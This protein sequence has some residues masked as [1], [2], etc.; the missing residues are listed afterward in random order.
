V[1][2]DAGLLRLVRTQRKRGTVEKYYTAVSAQIVV[3]PRMFG[4]GLVRSVYRGVLEATLAEVLKAERGGGELVHRLKIRTTKAK[5]E[6]L[7][8]QLQRWIRACR[9]TSRGKG[10]R[11]YGITV[12][13][14]PG[15]VPKRRGGRP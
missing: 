15:G 1:L 3:D 11:E 12:A 7:Q 8:R 5:A 14:Y 6:R 2:V 13:F 10:D 4:S 9:E